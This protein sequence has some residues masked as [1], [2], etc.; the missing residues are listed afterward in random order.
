MSKPYCRCGLSQVQ[1]GTLNVVELV[2]ERPKGRVEKAHMGVTIIQLRWS[3]SI[4]LSCRFTSTSIPSMAQWLTSPCLPPC[5]NAFHKTATKT[6][7]GL[8]FSSTASQSSLGYYF[9]W[10]LPLEETCNSNTLQINILFRL[11][12]AFYIQSCDKEKTLNTFVVSA[13]LT[14]ASAPIQD[15]YEDIKVKLQHLTPN[16]VGAIVL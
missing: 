12:L 4:L 3:F 1:I 10:F 15:L 11:T 9:I 13:S 2:M 6:H 14:N 16:T 7:Q 5:G 8:C